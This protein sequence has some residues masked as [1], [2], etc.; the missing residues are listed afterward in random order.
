MKTIDLFRTLEK[1]APIRL[2]EEFCSRFGAYDNSGVLVDTGKEI[3]GVLFSL[4]LSNGAVE[5]AIRLGANAVVTHHPAIYQKIGEIN[6]QTPTGGKLIRCIE[7]GVS[8]VSMHLNL[9]AAKGGTDESLAEAVAART[10]GYDLTAMMDEISDGEGYGRAYRLK[11]ALTLAE[12]Y[13]G[14]KGE[15]NAKNVLLLG[16]RNAKI[17]RVA[18]FCGGGADERA[19]AF[20]KESG[21]Q[22]LISADFKHHILAAALEGGMSVIA[23]TH[24][25][26]EVYGFRKY[27]EKISREAACPCVFHVDEELL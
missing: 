27:Y 1:Y 21:A 3:T 12:L 20:A 8:V 4:D 14:L 25:A 5:R 7:N 17:E 18:S 2:S 16:D 15:L 26:S 10:G 23:P 13:E 19:L 9:D 22:V 6:Y 24:Y 11:N